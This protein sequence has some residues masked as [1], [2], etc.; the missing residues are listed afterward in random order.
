MPRTKNYG[1]KNITYEGVILYN[2]LPDDIKIPKALIYLKINLRI[3]LLSIK[4]LIM[5]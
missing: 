4:I 1:E 3:S 5:L 2:K